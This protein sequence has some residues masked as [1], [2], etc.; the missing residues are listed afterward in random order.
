MEDLLLVEIVLAELLNALAV[1]LGAAGN[2]SLITNL[3]V[4]DNNIN[5]DE[6]IA[7][8]LAENLD[9][10]GRT[11]AGN[12]IVRSVR[13]LY[14]LDDHLGEEG[15]TKLAHVLLAGSMKI[16]AGQLKAVLSC[17]LADNI[18]DGDHREAVLLGNIIKEEILACAVLTDSC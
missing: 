3:V 5:K 14:L 1:A 16:V 7:E 6:I 12:K 10:R 18:A 15:L 11:N 17:E 8:S 4:A 2:H 9:V 13:L